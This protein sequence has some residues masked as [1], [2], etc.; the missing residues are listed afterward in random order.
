[1]ANYLRGLNAGE[2]LVLTTLLPSAAAIKHRR[3]GLDTGELL[4]E[5]KSRCLKEID[6]VLSRLF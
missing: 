4:E 3:P 6:L 1:M 2:T 5:L